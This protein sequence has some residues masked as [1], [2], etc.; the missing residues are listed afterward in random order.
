M[1]NVME[2]VELKS[3]PVRSCSFSFYGYR[4]KSFKLLETNA[5]KTKFCYR[6]WKVC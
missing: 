2:V 6:F 1:K 3:G 4:V 5:S